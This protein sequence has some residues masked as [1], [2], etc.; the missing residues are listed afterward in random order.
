MP[1][2]YRHRLRLEGGVL[3]ALGLAASVTLVLVVD[4]ARE[5]PGSTLVQLAVVAALL[6]ALGPWAVRRWARSAE[7]VTAEAAGTGEPTPLWH[8]PLVVVVLAAPFAL[9]GAWDA[10]LR[11]TAG[12]AL[13]GLAQALVLEGTAAREEARSGGGPLVRLPGSRL[14]GTRLGRLRAPAGATDAGAD[15]ASPTSLPAQ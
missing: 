14:F 11:V 10:V 15:E 7:P 13:V 4:A 6:L 2:T 9:L 3:A 12:S 8:L 1:Q 5:S